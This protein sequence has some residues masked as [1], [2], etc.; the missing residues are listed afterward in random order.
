MSFGSPTP[1]EVAVEGVSLEDDY[2]FAVRPGAFV[3]VGFGP[4]VGQVSGFY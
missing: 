2:G 3:A 4:E 1:V